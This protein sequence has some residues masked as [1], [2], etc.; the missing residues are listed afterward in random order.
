MSF[1]EAWIAAVWG[2][3]W[4]NLMMINDRDHRASIYF[5]TTVKLSKRCPFANEEL[6]TGSRAVGDQSLWCVK[7]CRSF[8]SMGECDRSCWK[9]DLR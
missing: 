8:D 3:C 7:K 1:V 2:L 9:A 4:C 5:G 6:S